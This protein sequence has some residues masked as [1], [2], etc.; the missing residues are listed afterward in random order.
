M[1]PLSSLEFM[2]GECIR[3]V[4]YEMKPEVMGRAQNLADNVY[5]VA[6]SELPFPLADRVGYLLGI[7]YQITA[8]EEMMHPTA[9]L[10]L[11]LGEIKRK[12]VVF[13]RDSWALQESIDET[14][15]TA[16]GKEKLAFMLL[17]AETRRE[18]GNY[19]IAA[20]A[21]TKYMM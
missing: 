11:A 15:E 13:S 14:I 9:R 17:A 19:A 1:D 18:H 10:D 21:A 6:G 2:K 5:A 4:P 16:G 12:S 8:H 3:N 20:S 7:V